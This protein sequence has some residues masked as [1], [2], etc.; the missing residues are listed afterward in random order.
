MLIEECD[1]QG[2]VK[3]PAGVFKPYAGV[4]T[5]VLIFVKGGKTE[6]VWYYD[7]QA[8]G[9]SLDDKRD[10]VSAND[11]PDV[12]KRW[13]ERDPVRDTDR[14]RK[15]FFVPLGEIQENKYDLS[16][17]RYKETRGEAARHDPPEEILRRLR[18]L[19]TEIMEDLSELERLTK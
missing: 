1:L 3:M 16:M 14:T 7:M 19:E 6:H 4:S 17:N 12:I 10:K 13:K 18:D 9:F 11:I 5:A 2:I 8:D 15:A